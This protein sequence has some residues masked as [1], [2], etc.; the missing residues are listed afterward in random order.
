MIFRR[1]VRP[2]RQA[3]PVDSLDIETDEHAELA[4][5]KAVDYGGACSSA[6]AAF[7][8]TYSK[9]AGLQFG[10]P[11]PPRLQRSMTSPRAKTSRPH[12]AT[13]TTHRVH[14][15]RSWMPPSKITLQGARAW[16]QTTDD[17]T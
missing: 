16:L 10:W 3:R 9:L 15:L 8:D 12:H 4:G 1:G 11:E 13:V 14:N 17:P 2:V 7:P 6:I 5:E